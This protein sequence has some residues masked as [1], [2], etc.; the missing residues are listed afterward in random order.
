MARGE[1][2][3]TIQNNWKRTSSSK[4]DLALKKTQTRAERCTN[5]YPSIVEEPSTWSLFNDSNECCVCF[6]T[7]EEDEEDC[8]GLE[9]VHCVCTRWIHDECVSEIISDEQGHELLC[10]FCVE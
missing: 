4:V 5:K 2:P 3:G 10:P 9:W 1:V 6:R 8:T 7:Y